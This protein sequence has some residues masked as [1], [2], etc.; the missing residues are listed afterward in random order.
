MSNSDQD[1]KKNIKK[2]HRYKYGIKS[3][4]KY[5]I[6]WHELIRDVFKDFPEK[7]KKSKVKKD[8]DFNKIFIL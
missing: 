8:K 3:D 2:E 7:F 4:I 5:C 1:C 6:D